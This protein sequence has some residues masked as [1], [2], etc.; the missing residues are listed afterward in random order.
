M[1]IETLMDYKNVYNNIVN[2]KYAYQSYQHLIIQT[3]TALR[4]RRYD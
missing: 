4:L 1:I 3:K 2:C